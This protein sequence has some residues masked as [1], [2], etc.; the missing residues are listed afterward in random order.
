[1]NDSG[2]VD[3]PKFYGRLEELIY[4]IITQPYVFYVTDNSR[5]FPFG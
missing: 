5:D 2:L 3:N 4:L 1:M